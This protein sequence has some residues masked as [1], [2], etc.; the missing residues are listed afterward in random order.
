[1]TKE[2]KAKAY[3]HIK[4]INTRSFE[5]RQAR[6]SLYLA[7]ATQAGIVVSEHEVDVEVARRAALKK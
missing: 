1:M 5:R 2:D 6:I 4:E 3:D 7:K